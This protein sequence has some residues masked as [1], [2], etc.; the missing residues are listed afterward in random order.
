MN[1]DVGRMNSTMGKIDQG[2]GSFGKLTSGLASLGSIYIGL[3]SLGIAEEELAIK[4]D[5][6]KMSKAEL[7]HM[8]NTRRK[9]T[10]SYMGNRHTP[11]RSSPASP[12]RPSSGGLGGLANSRNTANLSR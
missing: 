10:A 1:N 7:E 9:L 4:Q 12:S 5:Q 6:W 3:K 11:G 8:Q 2:L